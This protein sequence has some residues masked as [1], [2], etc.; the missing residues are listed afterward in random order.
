MLSFTAE[1]EARMRAMV[2]ARAAVHDTLEQLTGDFRRL[3]PEEITAEIVEL[4]AGSPAVGTKRREPR[5]PR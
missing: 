4:S 2:A 5:P 3:R 1:N